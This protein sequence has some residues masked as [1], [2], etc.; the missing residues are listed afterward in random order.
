MRTFEESALRGAGR[1]RC[2]SRCGGDANFREDANG[3]GGQRNY[4]PVLL[5]HRAPRQRLWR[6]RDGAAW[7]QK[8]RGVTQQ[9]RWGCRARGRAG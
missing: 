2:Y 6:E 1:K 8:G 4:L 5:C 7:L 9:A 3:A